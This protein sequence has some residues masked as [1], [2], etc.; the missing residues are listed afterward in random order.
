MTFS[1]LLILVLVLNVVLI[2]TGS[3]LLVRRRRPH[4]CLQCGYDTHASSLR[5]PECGTAL[6]QRRD[7][8]VLVA[9]LSGLAL[10]ALAILIDV[11]VAV[12]MFRLL[13]L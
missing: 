6:D 7:T 12:Y 9:R 13:T 8:R 11:G 5:C 2:A 3:V 4:R 1:G 10:I